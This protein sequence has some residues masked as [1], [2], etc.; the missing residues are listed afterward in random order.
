LSLYIFPA[1][2]AV[3]TGFFGVA[4]RP[5]SVAREKMDGN[6]SSGYLYIPL[7]F[8]ASVSASQYNDPPRVTKFLGLWSELRFDG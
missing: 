6:L 3:K 8:H 7:E 2:L 5:I 4:L 1:I